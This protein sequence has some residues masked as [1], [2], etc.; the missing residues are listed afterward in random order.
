MTGSIEAI[1]LV[2]DAGSE[3]IERLPIRGYL[4]H[5]E[6]DFIARVKFSNES[7]MKDF[8]RSIRRI[9]GSGR[10]KLMP[11][12]VMNLSESG[13]RGQSQKD[14]GGRPCRP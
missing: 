1:L 7:E 6:Y 9:I 10:F 5:G 14:E 4:L 8:E 2:W 12:K 13:G 3:E 11:V